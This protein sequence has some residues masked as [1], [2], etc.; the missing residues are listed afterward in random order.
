MNVISMIITAFVF[1][2]IITSCFVLVGVAAILI[3]RW[4]SVSMLAAL[5][6]YCMAYQ[7][8]KLRAGEQH[9]R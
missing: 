9:G 8:R 4:I 3:P 6:V 7:Y 2:T 1:A 5:F